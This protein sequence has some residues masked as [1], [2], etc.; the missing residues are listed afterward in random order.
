[1]P[2]TYLQFVHMKHLYCSKG[3]LTSPNKKTHIGN[4]RLADSDVINSQST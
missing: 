1:M 2:I 3:K 4:A